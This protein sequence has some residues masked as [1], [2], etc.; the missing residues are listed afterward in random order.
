M[1]FSIPREILDYLNVLD[2]FIE[3]TI[4]PLEQKDDNIRF[5]DHRRE[6]S[7]T[8]WD[9]DGLPSEDWEDLLDEMRQVAD[10]QNMAVKMAQTYQWQ[11]SESIWLQKV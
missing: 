10:L 6:H 9:R 11:L 2:R 1:D 3:N 7:R 4:K 8:D 5:F